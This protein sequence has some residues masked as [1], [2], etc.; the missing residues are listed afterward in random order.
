MSFFFSTASPVGRDGTPARSN[1][2]TFTTFLRSQKILTIRFYSFWDTMVTVRWLGH[3]GFEF[4]F[5]GKKLLVDPFITGNPKCPIKVTDIREADVVC[6]THDH[7]DHF[8]DAIEICM[9]TGATF[10]GV[11]EL[12]TY[13]ES[14]GVKNVVSMNIGATVEV[15]DLEISM[16]PAFHSSTRGP[17]V[18]FVFGRRDFKVY[19]AGDTGLFSDMRLIGKLYKPKI[20]CLPIGGYYTMGPREAAEAAQMISAEVVIPMHYGTFPVLQQSAEEFLKTMREKGMEKQVSI[21]TPGESRDF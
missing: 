13:A 3:A 17:P 15:G 6:V 16:V 9:K 19:H 18:G 4:D 21:M 1:P 20:V 2:T 7:Q 14:S 12:G 8:G 10:V 5:N 11:F